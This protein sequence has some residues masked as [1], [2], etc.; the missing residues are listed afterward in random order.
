MYILVSTS[1]LPFSNIFLL[2][3]EI[4]PL[5][6]LFISSCCPTQIP[7]TEAL[8][9]PLGSCS[10]WLLTAHTSSL[11][12]K[13][14]IRGWDLTHLVM[15]GRLNTPHIHLWCCFIANDK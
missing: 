8:Y 14:T 5:S 7:F 13:I 10:G 11:L 15:L 1:Y 4:Y 9:S 2:L 3:S 12:Q 6:K